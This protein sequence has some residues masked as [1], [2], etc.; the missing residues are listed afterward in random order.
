MAFF[1]ANVDSTL[2]NDFDRAYENMA[3]GGQYA[4]LY[5]FFNKAEKTGDAVS[6]PLAYDLG[7]GAATTASASYNAAT[8]A[9]RTR[10]LV[11]P[12]KSYR[13]T[14]VDLSQAEYANGDDNSVVDLLEDE[15]QKCMD[16]AKMDIDAALGGTGGGEIGTIASSTG[17]G[18]Y[19]LTM[20]QRSDMLRMQVNQTYVSKATPLSG[21]LDTGTFTVTNLN[22]NALQATVTANSSWAPTNGH[23][24]GVNGVMAASTA[25]VVWPGIL[26]WI[27][28]A[29]ARPVSSTLFFGVD[30]S[31]DELKLAGSALDVSGANTSIGTMGTLEGIEMLAYQVADVPGATPDLVVMS[32]A[33]LGKIK[34]QL[35]TQGRY[36]RE[37][38]KGKGIEVYYQTVVIAGPRG[39]MDIIASSNWPSNQ[40]AILDKSS[41][42]IGSPGN[43]PIKP[44]GV[45]GLPFQNSPGQDAAICQYRVSCFVYCT[46]P[47]WN[48]CLT[49][50]P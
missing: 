31:V 22:V 11:T 44:A 39:D 47:G 12:F 27:P 7:V 24:F 25:A 43:Q 18:P 40:V 13:T 2:R 29:S 1:N 46:A 37:D 41:W 14:V 32:F 9:Q 3:F 16:A 30:R 6:I 42:T 17:S 28:P 33:Q 35:Q 36:N 45:D 49:V 26:G 8:L 23:V 48:A 38:R 4:A 21:S 50:K 5:G 34:A 20:S 19:V 10:F 15:A